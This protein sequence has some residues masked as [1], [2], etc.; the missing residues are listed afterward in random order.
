MGSVVAVGAKTITDKSGHA[1]VPSAVSVCITPGAMSGSP[2]P[3][4]YPNT[5]PPLPPDASAKTRTKTDGALVVGTNVRM[6]HGAEAGT[7]PR[8]MTPHQVTAL[9]HGLQVIGF[10]E[11]SARQMAAGQRPATPQDQMLLCATITRAVTA[12]ETQTAVKPRKVK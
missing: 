8:G 5:A 1:L 7:A 12:S 10:S 6:S 9:Q 2:V 4:P 11:S 3:I